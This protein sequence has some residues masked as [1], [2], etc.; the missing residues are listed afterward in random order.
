M[1]DPVPDFLKDVITGNATLLFT[2]LMGLGAVG[3]WSLVR[4]LLRRGRSASPDG[5][6]WI[7][8]ER[9]R[10]RVEPEVIRE[11]SEALDVANRRL[12][13]IEAKAEFDRRLEQG[14]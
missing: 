12:D 3:L 5:D 14:R 1:P 13:R 11:L 4:G 6:R 10:G 8:V 7:G 9:A 2:L